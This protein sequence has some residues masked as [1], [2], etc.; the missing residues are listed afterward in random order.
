M[1]GLA[2]PDTP[3]TAGHGR[4][5][6]KDSLEALLIDLLRARR[7]AQPATGSPLLL[8][9]EDAHWLDPLSHDLLEAVGRAIRRAAGAAAAGLP[10]AGSRA[11][12]QAPRVA[13]LPHFTAV[14]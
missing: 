4:A 5:L 2:L 13:T 12:L 8:V 11:R 9:L 7:A 3:L 1:L 14:A 10:P 6:R